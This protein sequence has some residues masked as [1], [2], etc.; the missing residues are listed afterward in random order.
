MDLSRI[1]PYIRV[2][3]GYWVPKDWVLHERVIFDY[4]LLYLKEGGARIV[5][6][7]TEY[8]CQK[9]DFFLIKPR[10]THTIYSYGRDDCYHLHVHFDLFSQ[11]DSPEV[12]VCYRPLEAIGEAE[13]GWFREDVLS[14]KLCTIANHIR[15]NNPTY[16][17]KMLIDI[18]QEMEEKPVF[19]QENCKGYHLDKDTTP[20]PR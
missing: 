14:G 16:I 7:G 3:Y 15:L 8:I 5:V 11:D 1:S 17:E 6:E 10:Q 4:E 19:Y 13:K 2:A 9:G 12:K 18:I 20:I